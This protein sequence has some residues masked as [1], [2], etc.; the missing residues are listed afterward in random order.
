M[1]FIVATNVISESE[2]LTL[3]K[4][5]ELKRE[6]VNQAKECYRKEAQ[7]GPAK[8]LDKRHTRLQQL[9]QTSFESN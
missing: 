6:K 5:E 8:I 9:L 4:N 1:G 3:H 2:K 7:N